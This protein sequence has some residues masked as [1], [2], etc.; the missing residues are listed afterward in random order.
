MLREEAINLK[1]TNTAVAIQS[2][3]LLGTM[4]TAVHRHMK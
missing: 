3:M 4:V 1:A 2:E